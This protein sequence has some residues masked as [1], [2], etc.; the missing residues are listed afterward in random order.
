MKHRQVEAVGQT[1]MEDKTN[2]QDQT[3][4]QQPVSGQ[5]TGQPSAPGGSINTQP[6]SSEAESTMPTQ[7]MPQAGMPSSQPQ[8]QTFGVSPSQTA[9]V[10]G[11]PQKKSNKKILIFILILIFL[12]ILVFVFIFLPSLNK[13]VQAPTTRPAAVNPTNVPSQIGEIVTPS[14][15]TSQDANVNAVN[16]VDIGSINQDLQDIS[17]NLNQL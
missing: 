17:S 16:Q 8:I 9:D 1:N 10:S 14:P 12:I 4:S 15:V 6:A 2:Q 3:M 13:P 5:P 11:K 7:Q